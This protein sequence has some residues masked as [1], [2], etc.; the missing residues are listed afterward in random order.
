[1]FRIR[2]WISQCHWHVASNV[3][4]FLPLACSLRTVPFVVRVTDLSQHTCF[5]NIGANG[6]RSHEVRCT[7]PTD[8]SHGTTGT[9]LLLSVSAP[10][11]TFLCAPPGPLLNL[12]QFWWVTVKTPN[13]RNTFSVARPPS[14]IYLLSLESLLLLLR[15]LVSVKFNMTFI[16]LLI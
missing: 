7:N 15:V 1:M 12:R 3:S 10:R 14:E 11:P 8:S 5:I 13:P 16:Y 4:S 9:R 2:P 6:R